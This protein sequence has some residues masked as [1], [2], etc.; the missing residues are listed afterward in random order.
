MH[1][2]STFTLYI[3]LYRLY[4]PQT[5]RLRQGETHRISKMPWYKL[6]TY[7]YERKLYLKNVSSVLYCFCDMI[8]NSLYSK[9]TLDLWWS[10]S[11]TL[12][13]LGYDFAHSCSKIL[14]RFFGSSHPNCGEEGPVLTITIIIIS[15]HTLFGVVCTR[16]HVTCHAVDVWCWWWSFSLL[17]C[18]PWNV[19]NYCIPYYAWS[20]AAAIYILLVLL[21][22]VL[23][24]ESLCEALT[25]CYLYL[26][27]TY[28]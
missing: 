16:L 26:V 14:D 1:F 23:L 10:S 18:D 9:I 11:K 21:S 5:Q 4:G 7:I 27:A 8:L 28:M 12:Y 20:E 19:N 24:W 6:V 15:S 3:S 13:D 22:K 2:L 17:V 25:S